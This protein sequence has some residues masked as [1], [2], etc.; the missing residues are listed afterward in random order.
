MEQAATDPLEFETD[1]PATGRKPPGG[2]GASQAEFV[3]CDGSAYGRICMV[4]NGAHV[5]KK[6]GAGRDRQLE[7]T[8]PGAARGKAWRVAD[9]EGTNQKGQRSR[10]FVSASRC[11]LRQSGDD[12]LDP[13]K[14]YFGADYC[15]SGG[16]QGRVAL[17]ARGNRDDRQVGLVD[18]AP[19]DKFVPLAVVEIVVD[20][21]QGKGAGRERAPGFGQAGNDSDLMLREKE[22]CYLPGK[23]QVV[24]EEK[25]VHGVR[26]PEDNKL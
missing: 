16:D 8:S 11:I 5:K 1:T 25:D 24:L 19:A 21:H 4:G 14:L 10:R 26:R 13:V 7:P 6:R 9:K 23:N 18:P 2:C 15:G 20:K 17:F 3:F 12:L 22:L